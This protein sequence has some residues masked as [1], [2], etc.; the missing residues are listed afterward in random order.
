MKH[1]NDNATV[2]QCVQQNQFSNK[3][4]NQMAWI[5]NIHDVDNCLNLIRP[6]YAMIGFNVFVSFQSM[7]NLLICG[8]SLEPNNSILFFSFWL[9]N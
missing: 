8:V 4:S 5:L 2:W 7:C 6:K 1:M 9:H 3:E